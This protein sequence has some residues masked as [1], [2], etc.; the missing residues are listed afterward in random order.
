MLMSC[1]GRHPSARIHGTLRV[2]SITRGRGWGQAAPGLRSSGLCDESLWIRGAHEGVDAGSDRLAVGSSE[3]HQETS[4]AVRRQDTGRAQRGRG[5]GRQKWGSFRD[6][7]TG[8]NTRGWDFL[9]HSKY[10]A[11]KTRAHAYAVPRPPA[12][13]GDSLETPLT[14]TQAER[15]C[16]GAGGQGAGAGSPVPPAG[17][18]AGGGTRIPAGVPPGMWAS[19]RAPGGQGG[20]KGALPGEQ[21]PDSG[22]RLLACSLKNTFAEAP[23]AEARAALFLF[24]KYQRAIRN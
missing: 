2:S 15:W 21:P 13:H 22:P 20:C 3:G 1:S 10:S 17:S 9:C 11:E 23:F 19:W 8:G 24:T 5:V 7:R 12:A 14:S 18:A 4:G 16:D 6:V